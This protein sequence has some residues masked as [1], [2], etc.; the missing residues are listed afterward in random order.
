MTRSVGVLLAVLLL[1]L[2][3]LGS[4]ARADVDMTGSLEQ[5]TT[6]T[7]VKSLATTENG[8]YRCADNYSSIG[9]WY[10]YFSLGNCRKGWELEVVSYAS[11][12]TVTHEHSYGGFINNAFSGCGWIDTRFPLEKLNT[13]K[14]TA[15]AGGGSSREFKVEESTFMEKYNHG[16]VGDGDPVVNPNPCPE[17]ANYRPWSTSNDEKE[18]IRTVPAYAPEAPGSNYPALKWRYVTKYASTDGTG[19]YVMVRDDRITGAG[20]GNWV[21][22]PLSCLRKNASELPET[23]TERLPAASEENHPLLQ[24]ARASGGGWSAANLSGLF[25]GYP[26]LAEV[27]KPFVT[28]SGELLVFARS[29]SDDLLEFERP[30]TGGSWQLFNITELGTAQIV[31]TPT[32]YETK[33]GELIVV[34]EGFSNDLIQFWRVTGGGWGSANIT[35]GYGTAQIVSA[36]TPYETKSGELI[37]VA[38]GFSNDLIQF[39][40]SS[41]GWGSANITSGYGT[42]QIVSAPTPYETKS[43]ELIV[44]AEGFSNDLIQ[45]WRSTEGWRDV[46]VTSGY[47]TAQIVSPPTPIETKSGELIVVAEGFS[48]DLIQFWRSTEGWRD[49]NVT[50]SYGTAQIV[51][52]P[53]PF[54]TKSG[55]LVVLAQGFSEDLAQFTRTTEGWK[56]YNLTTLSGGQTVVSVPEAIEPQ[57]GELLVFS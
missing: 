28:K 40:R 15:C 11:E 38:E 6:Q 3:I 55:E 23:N 29:T 26:A 41:E 53:T 9:N 10:Y 19:K 48:N 8:T 49:V 12:N 5:V 2:M 24:F 54:E 25:T 31:S 42:A 4:S 1:Q 43:G 52:Q 27:S 37:V 17:Y 21:F 16:E 35:S 22:V 33:S 13:K 36:P 46:N 44:V 14:H 34:A 47:G 57:A 50:S 20:E 30:A 39:W 51:A 32:P 45:F 18:L 56:W 7:G